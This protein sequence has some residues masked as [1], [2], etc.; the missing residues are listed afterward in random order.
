MFYTVSY[1]NLIIFFAS[2]LE[3]ILKDSI[4]RFPSFEALRVR[5]SEENGNKI[6]LR[7]QEQIKRI[8][9]C[10]ILILNI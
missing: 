1:C 7:T 8:N 2:R 6:I 3:V 9:H 10:F 4:P 5:Q